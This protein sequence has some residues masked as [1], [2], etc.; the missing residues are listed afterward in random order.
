MPDLALT[1]RMSSRLQPMRS[2]IWSATSSG[3]AEGRS[4]LF[5][6]GMISKSCSMAKYKLEMVCA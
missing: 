2:I 3:L 6:T 4:I 1:L 5:M